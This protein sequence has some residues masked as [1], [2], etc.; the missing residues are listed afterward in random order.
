MICMEQRS[1]IINIITKIVEG[2]NRVCIKDWSVSRMHYNALLFVME[3][4]V[5]IYVKLTCMYQEWY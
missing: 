2:D 3:L 5:F 1:T 4:E